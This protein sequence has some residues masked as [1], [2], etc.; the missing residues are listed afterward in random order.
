MLYEHCTSLARN[1]DDS[2]DSDVDSD[3]EEDGETAGLLDSDE[4]ELDP[5]RQ[6]FLE[7]LEVGGDVKPHPVKWE[8]FL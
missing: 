2:G 8:F 5:R 7:S 4:D 1:E 6:K 3:E